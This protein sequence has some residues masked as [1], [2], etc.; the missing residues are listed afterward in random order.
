MCVCVC[1]CVERVW[2]R[3]KCLNLRAFHP[4]QHYCVCVCMCVR[5]QWG[6]AAHYGTYLVSFISCNLSENTV[7]G[8]S[9]DLEGGAIASETNAISTINNC[10]FIRNTVVT[11]RPQR[12]WMLWLVCVPAYA[13]IRLALADPVHVSMYHTAP[14]QTSLVAKH[15]L[16]V[17]VVVPRMLG[18][19][20]RR[21]T[22][23]LLRCSTC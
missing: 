17:T 16:A 7:I 5:V 23:M 12:P 4:W 11:V 3:C 19:L 18:C 9:R 8:P 22:D 13:C 2:C 14:L 20:L 10:T 6:G 1:V 21:C 15:G